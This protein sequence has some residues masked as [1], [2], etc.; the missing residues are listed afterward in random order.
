MCERFVLVKNN[1]IC[2]HCLAPGH[3]STNC[4]F[5]KGKCGVDGCQSLHHRLLHWPCLSVPIES[6]VKKPTPVVHRSVTIMDLN[7]DVSGLMCFVNLTNGC[8]MKRV[9]TLLSTGTDHT[10]IDDDLVKELNLPILQTGIKRV[11]YNATSQSEMTTNLVAFELSPL[12]GS[13]AKK[14]PIQAF[15]QKSIFKGLRVPNWE[16]T[17]KKYPHLRQAEI[18]KHDPED[19]FQMVIGCDNV[20]LFF[21][22]SER[23]GGDQGPWAEKSP[24]GWTFC[25][26]TV[27]EKQLKSNSNTIYLA[28]L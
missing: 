6:C 19:R 18:P 4:K 25:G 15:T 26:K 7:S 20:K 27:V 8:V 23:Y 17:A 28:V 16:N 13:S 21:N 12:G 5:R 22:T 10:V 3:S 11:L 9:V 14:H 24:L 1:S 2:Y